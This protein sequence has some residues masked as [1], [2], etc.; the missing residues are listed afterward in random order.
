M[1]L[2]A[3]AQLLTT[4][5][6]LLQ[7]VSANPSLPQS[8]RDSAQSIAQQS[9]TAATRATAAAGQEGSPSCTITSDKY[10]YRLGEIIV[11]SWE[12]KNA[13]S[14]SFMQGSE[15]TGLDA[16][17]IDLSMGGTWNAVAKTIGYPFVTMSVKDTAGR[18][19]TCSAM[20]N[21]R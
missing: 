2:E 21:V 16:P 7:T 17:A 4:A 20:V 6:M 3:A 1:T 15:V 14:L 13:A 8:V 11:L 9:I 19:A 18:S 5:L 10:N 12:S